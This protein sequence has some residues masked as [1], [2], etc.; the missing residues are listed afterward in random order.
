MAV[1]GLLCSLKDLDRANM[2]ARLMHARDESHGNISDYDAR[3]Y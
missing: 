1:T 2:R 3:A